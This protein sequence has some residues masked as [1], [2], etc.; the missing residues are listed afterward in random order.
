MSIE[1]AVAGGTAAAPVQLQMAVGVEVGQTVRVAGK[2]GAYRVVGF[3]PGG[4]QLI[5]GDQKWHVVRPETIRAATP[6]P[7]KRRR[8]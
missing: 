1:A 7:T 5:D 2:R 3:R 8:A 4:V 6:P